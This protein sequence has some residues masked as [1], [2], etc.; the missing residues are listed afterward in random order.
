[1][2]TQTNRIARQVIAQTGRGTCIFN[3]KLVDGSRSLKVW[4]W[5]ISEYRMAK[6]LLEEAGCEA[7]IKQ[8]NTVNSQGGWVRKLQTR[9]QVIE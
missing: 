2:R 7:N 9:L 4:G 6:R 8:F 5:S 1:M 3:D